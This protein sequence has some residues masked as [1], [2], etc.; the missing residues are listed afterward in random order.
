MFVRV[1]GLAVSVCLTL[2][3]G[4]L[5]LPLLS[6]AGA[7]CSYRGWLI[8]SVTSTRSGAAAGSGRR[9]SRWAEA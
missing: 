3:D 9:T 7:R 4:E 5:E 6:F 2:A 8:I 1:Q